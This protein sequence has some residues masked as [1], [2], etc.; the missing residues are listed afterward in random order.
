MSRRK[1]RLTA[2]KNWERK[3]Y[4]K[5]KDSDTDLP[6]R[7]VSLVVKIP[8]QIADIALLTL[9]VSRTAFDGWN[10]M[11]S[12]TNS[13]RLCKMEHKEAASR[14]LMTLDLKMGMCSLMVESK[15]VQLSPDRVSTLDEFT[16]LVQAIDQRSV[17]R[18]IPDQKF[19]SLITRRNGTFVDHFGTLHCTVTM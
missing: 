4:D 17:C 3:K 9:H 7:A 18:G 11:Y 14:I 2:P 5:M 19:S 6:P 10:L 13:V 12:T 1:F 16:S 15:Q 8:R